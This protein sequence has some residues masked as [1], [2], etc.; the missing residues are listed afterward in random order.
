MTVVIVIENLGCFEEAGMGIKVSTMNFR[1]SGFV[2]CMNQGFRFTNDIAVRVFHV[3]S[4][5]H[6]ERKHAGTHVCQ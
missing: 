1:V 3:A 5:I 4:I 6:K 2:S